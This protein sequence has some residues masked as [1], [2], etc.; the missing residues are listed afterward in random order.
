MKK[1]I[2]VLVVLSI[3]T[4]CF[5]QF[6]KEPYTLIQDYRKT[7]SDEFKYFGN[8]VD[9]DLNNDGVVDTAFIATQEVSGQTSFYL[10]G[11]IKKDGGYLLT[12]AFLIG[13]NIS[14]Q[15]TERMEGGVVINFAIGSN[16]SIGK[17]L[18]LELN[19]KTLEFVEKL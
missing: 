8:E 1:L 7:N 5:F 15:T 6:K 10:I 19:S 13:E 3:G 2:L 16:P 11:A 17:S 14:P 4:L 9:Q 18:R 12:K